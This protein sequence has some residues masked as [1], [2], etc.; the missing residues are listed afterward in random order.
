MKDAVR[1]IRACCVLHNL[2]INDRLSVDLD[3]Y[4]D[5]VV[6]SGTASTNARQNEDYNDDPTARRNELTDYALSKLQ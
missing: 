6:S 2:L 3:E 5:Q 1:W 4:H